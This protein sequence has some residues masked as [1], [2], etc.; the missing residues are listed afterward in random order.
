[1]SL[2]DKIK[3]AKT[4]TSLFDDIPSEGIARIKK[5]AWIHL[6]IHENQ[7]RLKVEN[8]DSKH[9]II[10]FN[11]M[12][13]I[14]GMGEDRIDS[15]NYF[16]EIL[17]NCYEEYVEC[18]ESELDAGALELRKWLLQNLQQVITPTDTK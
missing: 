18:D 12:P 15:T 9:E 7:D 8:L 16:A 1:M 11:D 17:L 4:G 3:N 2:K 13:D 14:F 10:Y 6:F 5:L